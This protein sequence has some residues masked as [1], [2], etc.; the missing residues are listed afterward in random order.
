MADT[1]GIELT[2]EETE[3]INA[4]HVLDPPDDWE[5]TRDGRIKEIQGNSNPFVHVSE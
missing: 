4:W 3:L 2:A 5:R 1:Y